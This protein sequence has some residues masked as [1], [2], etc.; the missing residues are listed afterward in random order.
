GIIY[1]SDGHRMSK[2][3]G[4]VVTPDEVIDRYGADALRCFELF[5]G[6]FELDN[7][8]DPDGPKGQFRF[9][10][11]VW[12]LGQSNSPGEDS[13]DVLQLLHQ[14]IKDVTERL[15]DF[16]FN[17]AVSKLHELLNALEK[18]GCSAQTVDALLLLLAPIAPHMTE[19]LWHSR[20]SEGG[21]I[22]SKAWPK[23]DPRLA[24]SVECS[25]VVQVNG[26]V[27]DTIQAALDL[28]QEQVEELARASER[29]Q[30]FLDGSQ[31][32]KVIYVRNRLINLVV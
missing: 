21:S 32:R 12:E 13:P 25:I 26:K 1:G 11:R 17:T 23:Y 28:P 30:R 9:L 2:S 15:E 24:A 4:N 31:V 5:M 14:T 6:P 20:H 10:N 27:R 29:V 7:A 8:W 3:R 16:R 19:E 22:H 18:R